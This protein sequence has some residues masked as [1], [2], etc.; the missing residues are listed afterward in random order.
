[1]VSSAVAR[2]LSTAGAP[3]LV[4][5]G[6]LRL[7]EALEASAWRGSGRTV[8]ARGLCFA[9]AEASILPGGGGWG[10]VEGGHLSR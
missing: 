4:A 10:R 8:E 7:G 1:V 3:V 6:R 9:A 5:R 2:R